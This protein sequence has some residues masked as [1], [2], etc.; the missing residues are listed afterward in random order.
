M[1][2]DNDAFEGRILPDVTPRKRKPQSEV[3][4][5]EPNSNPQRKL[6]ELKLA[7]ALAIAKTAK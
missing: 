3:W 6:S 1:S 2:L 4:I 7:R 5:Q